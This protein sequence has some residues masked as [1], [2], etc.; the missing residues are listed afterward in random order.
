MDRGGWWGGVY[1]DD[2][3]GWLI[4]T[5]GVIDRERGGGFGWATGGMPGGG[6]IRGGGRANWLIFRDI[7]LDLQWK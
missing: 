7:D 1:G 2:G 3:G 4:H 6:V 5:V